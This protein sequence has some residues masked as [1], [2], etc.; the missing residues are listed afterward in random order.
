MKGKTMWNKAGIKYYQQAESKWR[1]V[2]NNEKIMKII[3]CGWERL[4]A[5]QGN[6]LRVGD[7]SNKTFHYGNMV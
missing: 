2:N 1:E 6:K 5:N 7:K 4:L 3:Y